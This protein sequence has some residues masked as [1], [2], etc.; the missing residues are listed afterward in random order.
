[1]RIIILTAAVAFA[2][3][4][5]SCSSVVAK[6]ITFTQFETGEV[7]V[8]AVNTL[9]RDISVTMPGG[10]A[11]EGKFTLQQNGDTYA[12]LKSSRSTLMLELRATVSGTSGFG[13]AQTNSG[14]RYRV[15]F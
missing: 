9:T 4:L 11:L 1:M 12:L 2:A 3:T 10:E 15:Q 13:E 6:K 14:K 8:G 5:C 7:I